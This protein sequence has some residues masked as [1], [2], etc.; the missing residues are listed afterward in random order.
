MIRDWI[1]KI[2]YFTKQEKQGTIILLLLLLAA[3]LWRLNINY[4]HLPDIDSID[5]AEINKKIA[6]LETRSSEYY[7][8]QERKSNERENIVTSNKKFHFDP[9]TVTEEE[10]KLLGFS[11]FQ[12]N[13]ILKYRSKGG[14]FHKKEDL[15]KIYG[16]D[17]S[18][19]DD[20][21]NLIFIHRDFSYNQ[22]DR[23]NK[24][25]ES[26]IIELNTAD[27]VMLRSVK[28]IGEVYAKRILKYRN[29][30]GGY[31]SLNQ[32]L[33]VYGIDD[34]VYLN[35]R[36]NFR[37]DTQLIDKININTS[38]YIELIRHPYLEKKHVEA[39]L[40]YLTLKNEITSLNELI[41]NN[42]ISSEEGEKLRPYIIF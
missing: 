42:I 40:H 17:D 16:I 34:S 33:E 29:L 4:F 1:R 21:E 6:L 12:R 7:N 11:V 26:I 39:I 9:N 38:D 36:D 25:N 31:Y 37:V 22:T 20:L 18:V 23:N 19:F 10:M 32:L 8:R 14:V 3:F 2:F 13:N 5:T 30:L 24:V 28:G 15:K 41:K 35:I 27:T